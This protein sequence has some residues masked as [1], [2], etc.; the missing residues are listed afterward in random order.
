MKNTFGLF[1]LL[2]ICA[3]CSTVKKPFFWKLEKDGK[4]SYA[5]GTIHAGVDIREFPDYVTDKIETSH[6]ILLETDLGYY[7]STLRPLETQAK[8]AKIFDY[9]KQLKENIKKKKSIKPLFTDK[10]WTVIVE[11]AQ[12]L[13]VNTETLE[14]YPLPALAPLVLREY[15]TYVNHKQHDVARAR[16]LDASI[17]RRAMDANVPIFHL[18]TI[19]RMSPSCLD[20]LYT[21]AIKNNVSDTTYERIEDLVKLS[22][23]YKSGEEKLVLE[24]TS[25]MKEDLKK[26]LLKE[27]NE[28][29]MSVIE[30]NHTAQSPVF[31]AGGILHFIDEDNILLSLQERGFKVS[32]VLRA[33]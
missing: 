22:D 7:K 8:T 10:E 33:E 6:L 17:E 20:K 19:E 27:R 13:K 31:I 16:P 29:W 4:T 15:K 21:F 30:K 9:A 18:D 26:C 12:E 32:R 3:A 28:H 5:L 1:L 25:P 23:A 14:Y 24:M 2:L 11:R